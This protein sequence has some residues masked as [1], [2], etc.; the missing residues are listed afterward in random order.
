MIYDGIVSA[1]GTAVLG[2]LINAILYWFLFL[3]NVKVLY[4]LIIFL[5]VVYF[6]RGAMQVVEETLGID[7]YLVNVGVNSY[8]GYH[9]SLLL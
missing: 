2:F 7:T 8:Y 4:Y 1:I 3:I 5:I 6:I 9:Y